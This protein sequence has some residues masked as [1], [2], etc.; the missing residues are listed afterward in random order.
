[1]RDQINQFLNRKDPVLRHGTLGLLC[2]QTSFDFQDRQYLYQALSQRG[3]LKRLF[4]PEHGL[5]AELQDQIPLTSTDVYH[6]LR[7]DAEVVS[8][9]GDSEAS[10]VAAAS[11][12]EDLDA[13]VIDIQD[14]G[15]RYYTFATTV[16][17]IFDAMA[18]A[19]IDMDV[20]II[21]RP[22]PCGRQVEGSILPPEYASFV[23]KPGLPHKHG[24]TIAELCQFYK[25]ECKGEFTLHPIK[26]PDNAFIERPDQHQSF[27][28]IPPSPNMPG[29]LTPLVYTG[30]CLL[31]GTN[32]N[33][34]RGTTRP[35]EIFGAPWM[36]WIWERDDHPHVPGA[37]LRPLRYIPTFHKH[38]GEVCDGFQIHL[39]GEPYHSLAHSLQII[40]HIRDHSGSDFQWRSEA[41]EF[42]DDRPAIDL[43]AGDPVLLNYLHGDADLDIVKRVFRK[44][45]ARWISRADEFRI[46]SKDLFSVNF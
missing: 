19:G 41:Y 13:L 1:M 9:Y 8:L 14:V 32:L 21:D 31:E 43:L 26:L 12:L 15:S 30:Q 17:Y 28:I 18:R 3:V 37:C 39:T 42:R 46:Y 5:F 22:N 6:R 34:G 4:L 16:S 10:L 25:T 44:D 35:F 11:H 2:N 23:G 24:L 29:P 38:A 7:I 36:G 40:R 27:W 33:E 20:Y 45:E